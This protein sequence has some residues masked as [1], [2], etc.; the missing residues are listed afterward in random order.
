MGISKPKTDFGFMDLRTNIAQ[1]N[2]N[3]KNYA[4]KANFVSKWKR[5]FREEFDA[6]SVIEIDIGSINSLRYVSNLI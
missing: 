2:E 6:I 3:Q 5:S 1:K 4:N